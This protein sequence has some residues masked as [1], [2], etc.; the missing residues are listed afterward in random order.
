M[1][2]DKNYPKSFWTKSTH[3]FPKESATAGC[4]Q[5][6]MQITNSIF[7]F[8]HRLPLLLVVLHIW[9]RWPSQPPPQCI[10]MASSTFIEL[11]SEFHPPRAFSGQTWNFAD[12]TIRW[13]KIFCWCIDGHLTLRC[14]LK[15]G[16][17]TTWMALGW[18]FVP[19]ILFQSDLHQSIT[20]VAGNK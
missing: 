11:Q 1:T 4:F 6:W 18:H 3:A 17:R 12:C 13:G 16:A 20:K 14:S 8:F 2:K 19:G 15:K 5:S 7:I 9:P 10:A